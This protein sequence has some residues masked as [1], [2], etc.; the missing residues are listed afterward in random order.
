MHR[1]TFQFHQTLLRKNGFDSWTNRD[2]V[3]INIVLGSLNTFLLCY[4]ML[5]A[6]SQKLDNADNIDVNVMCLSDWNLCVKI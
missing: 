5:N 4:V 2:Q 3:R 1:V 6:S